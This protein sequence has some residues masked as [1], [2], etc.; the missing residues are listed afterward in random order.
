MNNQRKRRAGCVI[1]SSPEENTMISL[2][3]VALLLWRNYNDTSKGRNS[4][5]SKRDNFFRTLLVLGRLGLPFWKFQINFKT[6]N[7]VDV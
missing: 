3:L 4:L 1:C 7:F 5:K 2:F 6:D